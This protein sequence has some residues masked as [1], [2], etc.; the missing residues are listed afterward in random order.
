MRELLL[1]LRVILGGIL[2]IAGASKFLGWR[3][4]EGALIELGVP[5][6]LVPSLTFLVPLGEV[7]TAAL[8]A[9][10]RTVYSGAAAACVLFL[11]FFLVTAL[12][13]SLGRHPKCSCFGSVHSTQITWWAPLRCLGLAMLSAIVFANAHLL[14]SDSSFV[15]RERAVVAQSLAL[16]SALL[17]FGLLWSTINIKRQNRT[18]RK[19]IVEAKTNWNEA[20][21]STSRGLPIGALAPSFTVPKEDGR[22][23]GLS[24]LLARQKGLLLLFVEAR[25]AVCA[26]L[27]PDVAAC[28]RRLEERVSVLIVSRGDAVE[29]QRRASLSG[30][31]DMVMQRDRELARAYDVAVTPSGV[32][33]NADGRIASNLAEGALGIRELLAYIENSGVVTLN[34][35]LRIGAKRPNPLDE[36]DSAAT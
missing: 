25:C 2:G 13:I 5:E 35:T 4:F 24:E 34:A 16:A 19:R 28:C 1:L 6:A 20:S 18:S 31:D 22:S 36:R 23:L 17:C 26:T 29:S 3:S 10:S 21:A 12:N 27:L 9:F 15:H 7:A 32:L 8:L 11:A 14:A 33:I 30:F